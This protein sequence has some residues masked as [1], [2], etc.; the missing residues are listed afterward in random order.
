MSQ[1]TRFSSPSVTGK[2]HL[3]LDFVQKSPMHSKLMHSKLDCSYSPSAA[4]QLCKS[5]KA[6]IRGGPNPICARGL[7]FI[8]GFSLL[9]AC[10]APEDTATSAAASAPASSAATANQA[11]TGA[12]DK[13]GGTLRVMTHDSFA[14][15]E[16]MLDKFREQT[17]VTVELI[18]AGDAGQM[19]NRLILTKEAPLA[20]VVYGLDNSMLPKVKAEDLLLAYRSPAL[21][22]VAQ[23]NRLDEDGL[24]NTVDYLSLIHI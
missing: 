11:E 2:P 6:G 14:L 5:A 22:G 21:D 20:D 3:S 8:L 10:A 9:S 13:I 16:G 24:L 7:L 4:S 15:S 12:V 19:L 1:A 18:E 17:G 23:P